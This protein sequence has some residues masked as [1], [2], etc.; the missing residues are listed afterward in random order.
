MGGIVGIGAGAHRDDD[1]HQMQMVLQAAGGA[2]ANN[3]IDIVKMKQFVGINT[4]RRYSHT[5]THY[6]DWFSFVCTGVPEHIAD[7]I[8]LFW[9]FQIGFCDIFCTQRISRHQNC[10]GEISCTCTV[11]R[12]RYWCVGHIVILLL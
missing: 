1:I 12:S 6:R 7:S 5:G 8:D 9:V 11:V 4:D 2:D 3:V 10:F